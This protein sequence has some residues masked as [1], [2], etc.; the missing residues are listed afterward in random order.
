MN[1]IFKAIK[2]RIDPVLLD[3]MIIFSDLSLDLTGT[4]TVIFAVEPDNTVLKVDHVVVLIVIDMH[5]AVEG[6][7][8]DDGR[9]RPDIR[10]FLISRTLKGDINRKRSYQDTL[11]IGRSVLA[12]FKFVPACKLLDLF[13]LLHL[14]LGIQIDKVDHDLAVLGIELSSKVLNELFSYLLLRDGIPVT[15][16]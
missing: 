12:A 13:P 3:I 8:D 5:P 4:Y 16:L 14:E 7:E 2:V 1:L 6:I 9:Y 10:I 11:G 15:S